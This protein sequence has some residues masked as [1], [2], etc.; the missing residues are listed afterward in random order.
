MFTGSHVNQVLRLVKSMTDDGDTQL[1]IL[2]VALVTACRSCG[3][4][5]E[6]AMS[7][8]REAFDDQRQLVPLEN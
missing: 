7:C 2:T 5:R 4:N 1:S 3:V 8:I 6:M